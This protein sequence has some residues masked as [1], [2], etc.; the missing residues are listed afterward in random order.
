MS[1]RHMTELLSLFS[2]WVAQPFFVQ[3]T[4]TWIC[5]KQSHWCTS[6]CGMQRGTAADH[7]LNK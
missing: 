2:A 5:V 6:H 4:V 7:V 1:D 3:Q